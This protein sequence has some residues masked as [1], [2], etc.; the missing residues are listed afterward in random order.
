MNIN[1]NIFKQNNLKFNMS[2]K[3]GQ[4]FWAKNRRGQGLSTNAIILIILGV[5]VLIILALGFMMG[6]DKL[7][8][9]IPSDN[10]E[11]IKTSCASVCATGNTYGFCVQERTLKADGLPGGV[12]EVT[13]TCFE[14]ATNASYEKY[15]I[16]DCDTITCEG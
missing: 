11:T 8:P 3:R 6:W 16:E 13:E 5:I 4:F 14:F 7:F 2:D 9:F 15:G 1:K 12:K 10:V